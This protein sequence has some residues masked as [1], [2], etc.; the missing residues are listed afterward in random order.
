MGVRGF[1]YGFVRLVWVYRFI[2]RDGGDS[3]KGR[4][5]GRFYFGLKRE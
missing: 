2:F 1:R 3:R 4:F 5:K